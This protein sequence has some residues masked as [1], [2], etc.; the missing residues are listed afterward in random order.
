M[1]NQLEGCL[2]NIEQYKKSM[3]FNTVIKTLLNK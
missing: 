2:R 3:L 1:A